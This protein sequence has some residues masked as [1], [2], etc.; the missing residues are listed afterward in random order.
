MDEDEEDDEEDEEE[1]EMVC[2]VFANQAD[3]QMQYDD[4]MDDNDDTES[5][6]DEADHDMEGM[7]EGDWVS[8]IIKDHC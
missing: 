8:A 4:D 5:D 3:R 7:E 2:G 1:E 6:S